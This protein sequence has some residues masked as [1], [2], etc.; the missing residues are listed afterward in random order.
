MN[1]PIARIRVFAIIAGL[2]LSPVTGISADENVLSDA[3]FEAYQSKDSAWTLFNES[4][5]STGYARSGEK[6]V[7]NW[8]FSRTVAYPPYCLGTVSG[9]YQEIPATPGSRWQLTGYGAAPTELTGAPAF[10]IV[11]VSFFDAD[12]K[13]LGTV[14]TSGGTGPLAKISNE[15]NNMT[16]AGD[17]VFLDTGVAT[18][19]EVTT[20]IQAFT[21]FVD[22][23]GSESIQGVYF[24]DI[25][26]CSLDAGDDGAGC[27]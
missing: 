15:V 1:T 23:S 10:G 25:K 19:P 5:V 22:Y 14:E 21:L 17:W 26:L 18:A 6:S 4:R 24:D 20:S 3:G 7:F 16:P 13:D 27:K 11:Q 8:G 2:L 12:G 9:A